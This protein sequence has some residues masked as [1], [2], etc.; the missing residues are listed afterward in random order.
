MLAKGG[1]FSAF[2]VLNTK[3]S[4][5]TTP[6]STPLTTRPRHDGRPQDRRYLD[7]F[8]RARRAVR[9]GCVVG[10][11]SRKYPR[12]LAS[13]SRSSRFSS[14]NCRS[15]SWG[16]STS[17]SGVFVGRLGAWHL[18]KT[19]EDIAGSKSLDLGSDGRF[20]IQ[21]RPGYTSFDRHGAKVDQVTGLVHLA[22]GLEGSGGRPPGRGRLLQVLA[23]VSHGVDRR[24]GLRGR[25]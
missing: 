1:P 3:P 10:M 17:S 5:V 18:P 7:R 15:W 6:I 22:D 12:R 23:A 25:G 9:D 4:T 21:P 11:S 2:A 16:R 20:P 14:H 19:G 8:G 24:R 13:C